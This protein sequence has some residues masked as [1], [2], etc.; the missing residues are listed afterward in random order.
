MSVTTAWSNSFTWIKWISTIKSISSR[1]SWDRCHIAWALPGQGWQKNGNG[2]VRV[3]E[4]FRSF[5]FWIKLLSHRFLLHLQT[6]VIYF[7]TRL[8]K[9]CGRFYLFRQK[10]QTMNEYVN[11]NELRDCTAGLVLLSQVPQPTWYWKSDGDPVQGN[12]KHQGT[13][14]SENLVFLYSPFSFSLLQSLRKFNQ[15][16]CIHPTFNLSVGREM[17]R[18]HNLWNF[19]CRVIT[20]NGIW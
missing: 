8:S 19:G 18:A 14:S 7:K 13:V 2:P 1:L 17:T 15:C 20:I 12:P 6:N 16:H 5:L 4:P 9:R 10:N 11:S 3:W